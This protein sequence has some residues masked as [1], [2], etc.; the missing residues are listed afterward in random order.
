MVSTSQ[1]DID[2]IKNYVK[3]RL[4]CS[5]DSMSLAK[6]GIKSVMVC[7]REVLYRSIRLAKNRGPRRL[8]STFYKSVRKSK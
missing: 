1:I 7:I 2:K 6:A 3:N 4:K 8:F 5:E